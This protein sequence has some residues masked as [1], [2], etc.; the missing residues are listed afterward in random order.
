MDVMDFSRKLFLRAIETSYPQHFQTIQVNRFPLIF[1]KG[2]FL[3]IKDIIST[4]SNLQRLR[5]LGDEAVC[6]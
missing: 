3:L 2:L 1:L 4:A 5:V 6:T